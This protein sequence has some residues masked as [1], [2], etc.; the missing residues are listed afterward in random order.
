ME[1]NWRILRIYA[2]EA[3]SAS[4]LST[5]FLTRGTRPGKSPWGAN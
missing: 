2:L 5:Y 4:V 1:T 3:S